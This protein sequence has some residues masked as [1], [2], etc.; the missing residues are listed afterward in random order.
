VRRRYRAGE[1]VS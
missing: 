1:Y